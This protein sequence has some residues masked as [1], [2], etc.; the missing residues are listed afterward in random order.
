[1]AT[2]V[3]V[4]GP[5]GCGKSTNADRMKRKFS[6]DTVIDDYDFGCGRVPS[7]PKDGTLVLGMSKHGGPPG[8]RVVS[9]YEAIA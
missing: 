6:L 7:V 5:A 2:S 3:Y 4:Y 1:M 8:M 9:Y